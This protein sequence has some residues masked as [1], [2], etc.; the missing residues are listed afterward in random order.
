MV[1]AFLP[2]K[3]QDVAKRLQERIFDRD[4]RRRDDRTRNRG[5]S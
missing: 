1:C 3:Q 4:V 5:E 2:L